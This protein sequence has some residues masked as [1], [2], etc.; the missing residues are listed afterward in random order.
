MK[1]VW[2]PF[3][4]SFP[5]SPYPQA[6]SLTSRYKE[7]LP[8]AL[9]RLALPCP[10]AAPCQ[11]Y[12][13]SIPGSQSHVDPNQP[14]LPSQSAAPC[15]EKAKIFKTQNSM[16]FSFRSRN[17]FRAPALAFQRCGELLPGPTPD[18]RQAPDATKSAN[19][20]PQPP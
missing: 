4:S 17:V 5:P 9:P 2:K 10:Y 13:H 15:R 3:T 7:F 11:V 12:S 8:R 1:W 14:S 19:L 16:Q 6:K 20:T 18:T